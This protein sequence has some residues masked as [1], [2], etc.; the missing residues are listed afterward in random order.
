[1]MS[2]LVFGSGGRTFWVDLRASPQSKRRAYEQ[3]VSHCL[4]DLA[5]CIMRISNIQSHATPHSIGYRVGCMTC[6]TS[7]AES[8][9]PESTDSTRHHFIG[10]SMTECPNDD[11]VF[12]NATAHRT[13]YL[14]TRRKLVD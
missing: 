6:M 13:T 10:G 2:W 12:L 8:C 1:V 9:Q 4:I 5:Y 3:S 11:Q 7:G 14:T